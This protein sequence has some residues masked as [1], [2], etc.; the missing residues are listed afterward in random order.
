M[1]TC[2]I[3]NNFYYKDSVPQQVL[4][5]VHEENKEDNWTDGKVSVISHKTPFWMNVD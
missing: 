4:G 2:A 3:I 1:R 5:Y